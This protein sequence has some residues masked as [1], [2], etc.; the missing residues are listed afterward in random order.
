M[1][2][3]LL[4]PHAPGGTLAHLAACVAV[5][6]ALREQGDDPV[7]AYGGSRPELLDEAGI[8]WRPVLEAAGPMSV[9]W[10]ESE[11]HLEAVLASQLEVI[12]QVTPDACITSAGAGRLAVAVSGRPH[13]AL[14]HGLGNSSFGLR[15]RRRDAILGDLRRPAR[16]WRDLT[17]ALRGRLRRR[18][19]HPSG[20]IWVR[21]W[22][23]HLG[24]G[25]D[26]ETIWT[27]PADLAACTTTPLLDPAPDMPGHW[28]YVGPF[29]FAPAS[30]APGAVAAPANGPRAY[31]S[32]G[33][34]GEAKLLRRAVGELLGAGFA[35]VASTGGLCDP[36]QLTALGDGV[37]AAEIHDSRA[38]LA[39]A[40]LA[41]IGGGHMTAMEALIAG[42]PTLVVPRTTGQALA[43]KRAERLGTGIGLWPRL[44]RGSIGRAASRMISRPRYRESAHEVADH[45]SGWDGA[46]NAARL[47]AQL[48]DPSRAIS[49][50]TSFG[51]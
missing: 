41:V 49:A 5:A 42:T 40:D 45:L 2:R 44:P 15:G 47:S 22:A 3:F 7:L 48:A 16:A 51:V 36:S 13:L 24:M 27:G 14:M 38:E 18:R 12:E 46:G 34:T 20:R 25:L 9:D 28:R 23:R 8:D 29:S 31:V 11:D 30:T 33:S 37:A 32:Q 39:A 19:S 21:A 26:D 50:G 17:L 43:A 1:A 35:V 4:I 10:F 6:Q